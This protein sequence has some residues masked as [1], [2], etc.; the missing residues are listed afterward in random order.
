M[1]KKVQKELALEQ[2]LWNCRDILRGK[3]EKA[4]NRNAVLSLTF[5]KF[6]GEKFEERRVAFLEELK[7][8]GLPQNAIENLLENPAGY[9]S[10]NVFYLQ[11]HCRW[12]YIVE[13]AADT[14]IANI[15][16]TA[17]ADI[18]Q[19]NSVLEGA[20]P[21]RF[22][23]SRSNV[24]TKLLKAL[25]D[26]INKISPERFH[27][28]DLIGRV[29]EYFLQEF[30]I[31]ERKD[32]GEFY[33]PKCIVDLIAELIEPF[34][35]TIYDPCCGSG[36]MFV[37]SLRFVEA[38][39]G[40]TANIS[41]YGQESTPSTFQLAKMN[42]AIRGIS[43]NLGRQPASSFSDDQH[44]DLKFDFIMANP[45]FNL[46]KW[47]AADELTTDPRWSGYT[48]PPES[49]ANY[50]WILHMLSKLDVTSGIAGF[51][52]A[53][54]ALGA[55]GVEYEIRKQLIENDKVEAIIVLPREMFYSTDISV[56]LW[57]LN[58]NK[59]NT[60]AADSTQKRDRT[61]E[62]LFVDL[63]T[64]NT[65]IYEKSYV[66]FT[67]EQIAAI[68]RIY[69]DFQDINRAGKYEKPELY[70]AVKIEE[71]REKK[72]SLVP[73]QYIEFIDRDLQID[74]QAEM[75]RVQSEMKELLKREK[76]SQKQLAKAFKKLGYSIN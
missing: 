73:S 1:A 28:K 23:T 24:D 22:F 7:S 67:S 58:N 5:L 32:K 53:N 65:N 63:R 52:L 46:K 19:Q 47:R 20:L 72:H 2:I 68:K 50:A 6:A 76:Q 44:K 41:V 4:D 3:V 30:S 21:Q 71:L 27:E 70:R 39:G 33:T 18:E 12:T 61:N 59:K 35:G 11:P 38:H 34:K 8:K 57:V 69:S 42:L 48:T 15:L 40:N 43:H 37:Q 9:G 49:N 36:G 51:L 60:D 45:P 13:H 56:T 14:S 26:E 25:I 62:I 55:D 74:H 64:W 10:V 17:M 31:D 29:Y 16:D 75:S 66:Q 54:G